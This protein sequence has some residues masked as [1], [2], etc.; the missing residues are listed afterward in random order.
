LKIKGL[1][2]SPSSAKA[3]FLH[4]RFYFFV[5]L[6]V[7][8]TTICGWFRINTWF[9]V[10]LALCRL[11]DGNAPAN[12]R[13]AFSNKLFLSY[14]AIF[15]LELLSQLFT[16]DPTEGWKIVSRD[17]TLVAVPFVLCAGTF[18]DLPSYKKFMAACCLGLVL[19]SLAC[20]VR[21]TQ[22]Y[23]ATGDIDVFFYHPLVAPL[24]QNAVFYSVFILFGLFFL[25]SFDL[26]PVFPQ[27][28]PR[29]IRLLQFFMV[30]FFILMIVL[31]ASK[32]FLVI[33]L[34]SLAYFLLRKYRF[35]GNRILLFS[36]GGIL[37]LL[38]VLLFA[39]KNPIKDRY[40]DI[41]AANIGMIKKEHF[42]PG[43]SF[44]G[45][46]IR[47]LEWRFAVEILNEHRAWLWGTTPG[48]SQHLL[49]QKYV[50]ANMYLGA[51]GRKGRGFWDYNFHNQYI[52]TLVRTGFIGLALLLANLCLQ[53]GIVRRW[54]T[55]QAFFTVLTL[56]LF[57]IPQSPLTMQ[58]GVFLFSFFPLLL[59][60]SPKAKE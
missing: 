55:G 20:L 31:L 25:L 43:D 60:Y 29:L 5:A 7:F 2:T 59:T 53:I 51:P 3:P 40:N 22:H 26:R 15:L 52:E 38:I 41:L 57:F 58:T 27:L 6:G 50:D 11:V 36:L 16:A 56:L 30:F 28:P 34:L 49:N 48:Y 23:L 13:K 8:V 10:L 35:T 42:A 21:A 14:L 12:I 19:A 47:L 37:L 33:M 9:I 54:K 46:Q 39:T 18:A 4:N 24:S 32:L 17:A 44:N 1:S 45:I